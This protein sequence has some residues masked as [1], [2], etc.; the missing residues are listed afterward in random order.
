MYSQA[1]TIQLQPSELS[2]VPV[3]RLGQDRYWQQLVVSLAAD[4]AASETA[5][6]IAMPA[7]LTV[8]DID[9]DGTYDDEIRVVY[10]AVGTEIPGFFA[11]AASN[12]ESIIISSTQA[13]GAGGRIYLQFPTVSEVGPNAAEVRYGRID[14]ADAAENDL[15]EGPQIRFVPLEDFAVLGSMEVITFMPV[16]AAGADTTASSL[17]QNF[18]DADEVLVETLPDLIFD[19]ETST[20]SNLYGRGDDDDTN[21]VEYRFFFATSSNL[22]SVDESIAIEAQSAEGDL[23]IER[24]GVGRRLRLNLSALEPGTYYL[25]AVSTLTGSIPLGRSRGIVVVHAPEFLRLGP[26]Q[27]I[28]LDSGSL[29]DV[30]GNASGS[31]QQSVDIDYAVVDVDGTPLVH[32]FYSANPDLGVD[33]A[34][35][36]AEGVITLEDATR[37]TAGGLSEQEGV[38]SWNI[39]AADMVRAGSYFI[40][41]A[42]SDGSQTALR[43]SANQVRVRHA[44][45]LRLDALNDQAF[46]AIDTISTGGVNPQRYISISWGRSGVGGDEDI[47]D[48]AS[49]ELYYSAEKATDMDGGEGFFVPGGAEGM[50]TALTTGRS[51]LIF[52]NIAEDPDGRADNQHVWDLWSLGAGGDVPTEGQVYYIY[53]VISDGKNQRLVQMNA[54]LLNDAGSQVIFAHPP[55]LQLLQPVAPVVVAPGQSGRVSWLDADL[56]DDA[57]IRVL[58]SSEDHGETVSY[59]EIAAATSYVVNSADGSA[60]SAVDFDFDLSEDASIDH[61]DFSVEHI[62]RGITTDAALL[63]GDYS[64]YLAISDS[65]SFDGAL[66]W[67]APAIVQLQGVGG[68]A[69]AAAPIALLPEQ[70]SMVSGG[71]L[72][73]F[74]VRVEAGASVDLVQASFSVD[75]NSFEVVDHDETQ[76]GIQP[77]LVG[78]EFSA[79][80]L[81]TNRVAGDEGGPWILTLEYFEPTADEIIGLNRQRTLASFQL[82]SLALEGATTISLLVDGSVGGFSR[83]ERDGIAVV[84]LAP[85]PVSQG[86]IVAGRA[87]LRGVLDLEG[88]V[89]KT[90][91]ATFSLRSRGD[92]RVLDDGIFAEANDVDLEVAGA[93]VVV[94]ADGG[95]ELTE[96]P[97]GRWDLHV[98]VGGYIDGVSAGLMLYPTQ[99]IEGV[100]PSSPGTDTVARLLGGDVTGYLEADGQS[101]PDNEV[102]LADWDYVAAFFGSE[103]VAEDGSN[104]ADITGDGRVDIADLSLVGANFRQRGQQPVYKAIPVA[105]AVELSLVGGDRAV[106]AGDEVRWFALAEHMEGAR[107]YALELHYD[108]TEWQWVEAEAQGARSALSATAVMPYGLLWGQVQIGRERGLAVAGPLVQW[109]LRARVDGAS[110]PRLAAATFLDRADR[111]IASRLADEVSAALPQSLSLEQ[112]APNPFNPET[113]ISFAL[114]ST[115]LAKLEVYDVLGQRIAV[116]WEGALA[117][118]RYQMRWDGRDIQGRSAASGIYIYRLQSGTQVLAKRMVL[119]R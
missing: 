49:I 46:T 48:D 94:A 41:G 24:E 102:T 32:L 68:E 112:N 67:R 20:A 98:H 19:A 51:Q 70:F 40:Y 97:I 113:N 81:V 56:D 15:V 8:A 65:D 50:L 90:A 55:S 44:P 1:Q 118:G 27:D 60:G 61:L 33:N 71:A 85:S 26:E 29:Y 117:P 87:T 73:V 88:R 63:D 69:V 43:R 22:A 93:Q 5:L 110:A 101:V 78:S 75:S 52:G 105:A 115:E 18:P 54:G 35:V 114:P 42:A 106:R 119:L 96:V 62:I 76:D 57:R 16:L 39:L 79:A 111:E 12:A 100:S 6:T 2:R 28:T 21:D 64:L 92:Y 109:T 83:L 82:R 36:D 34:L 77:F 116:V 80:K 91:L 11:S 3:T 25:Y 17:G 30:A 47:D 38:F 53:G 37:L 13:A 89:D 108:T 7:G 4:D 58:L 66:C 45:F 107:A 10:E 31:G 84:E 95:F 9:E 74:E 103:V 14:F 72:Q 59:D 99:I 104:R 23:Y 86:E